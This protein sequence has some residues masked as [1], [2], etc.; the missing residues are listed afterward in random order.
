MKIY[1]KERVE[2]LE[3]ESIKKEGGIFV[4]RAT[5][6]KSIPLMFCIGPEELWEGKNLLT[7]MII[8]YGPIMFAK[9]LWLR[10]KRIWMK[11]K[12]PGGGND[13]NDGKT[14]KLFEGPDY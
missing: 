5:V 13:G 7:W 6:L 8:F 4:V 3:I 14:G 12:F 10:C 1:S 9:G 11:T 2:M